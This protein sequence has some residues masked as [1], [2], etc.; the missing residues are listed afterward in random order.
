M[1]EKRNARAPSDPLGFGA[2]RAALSVEREPQPSKARPKDHQEEAK[3][4]NASS[5]RLGNILVCNVNV[6]GICWRW[7]HPAPVNCLRR[8]E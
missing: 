8:T 2:D 3:G 6:V 7:G 4:Q 1:R 5:D